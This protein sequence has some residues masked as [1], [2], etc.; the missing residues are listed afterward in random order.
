[1]FAQVP[2]IYLEHFSAGSLLGPIE[3]SVTE[4]LKAIFGIASALD[5]LHS[6]GFVHFDLTPG[7][8][9]FNE[10]HD[11]CICD[12]NRS[13]EIGSTGIFNWDGDPSYRSPE[14]L[15]G[16]EITVTESL[17]IYAFGMLMVLIL[18]RQPPFPTLR[19]STA[20]IT[21]GLK[22]AVANIGNRDLA[23]LILECIAANPFERP[24]AADII[25]R[26]SDSSWRV[27]PVD[28][29]AF[30]EYVTRIERHPVRIKPH[31]PTA[32]RSSSRHSPRRP[33][34][35]PEKARVAPS[36]GVGRS[37]S[38]TFVHHPP[39]ESDRAPPIPR[40]AVKQERIRITRPQVLKTPQAKP[41]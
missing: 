20:D 14:L 10:A 9:L 12:F 40:P 31:P 21:A 13:L 26:L 8:V 22:S 24:T 6:R 16:H 2:V 25:S 35:C 27:G 29:A 30:D 39:L 28:W 33:R 15:T 37:T 19:N 3:L 5:Y 32:P 34:T 11:V 4:S 36:S 38:T 17:D 41:S 18:T 7:D 1:M 23:R